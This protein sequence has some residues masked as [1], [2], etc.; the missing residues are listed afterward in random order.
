MK[1]TDNFFKII[2]ASDTADGYVCKV[3]LNP[4]H[5]IYRVH[6]PDN[7]VTPGVCLIQMATELLEQRYDRKLLLSKAKSIKFKQIIGPDEEPTF[8]FT[9]MVLTDEQLAVSV[10]IEDAEAQSAVM[11][12]LFTVHGS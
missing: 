6:F 2:S 10:S 3:R 8:I 12:L 1:L 4:Q 9:K 5:P 7:P 11:S